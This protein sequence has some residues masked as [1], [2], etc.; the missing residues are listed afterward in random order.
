MYVKKSNQEKI[1]TIFYT[2]E[3]IIKEYWFNI[4]ST[5]KDIF[6]YFEKHIKEEG[7]SLKQNYKI[8]GKK[9]NKFNTITELIKKEKNDTI[10][11]GEIWI[12]VEEDVYFDDENDEIYYSIL[13]PKL[14][15]FELIEYNSIKSRIKIIECP[16]EI[17][18][19]SDL[20]KFNKA[21]AFC[22]SINS[23][24]ICG[25]EISGKGLNNF[26]IVNKN[27]Y[28]I[29]QKKLPV[30]KKYHSMLY[31][32]DNFIFVVGGDTLST[33]IYD[34][35]N[36]EFINWAKMNK[37]NFQPGLLINGDYVYSFTALND[38]NKDNNYFEKTNLTSKDPKWEIIYPKYDSDIKFNSYFFGISKYYDGDILFVGGEKNNP[39]Y[40]YNPI[41]N[42]IS[43]SNGKNV[44][45]PFWDKTFYKI[46]KKYN[47]CI[48]LNFNISYKIILLDKENESLEEIVC[49][50]NTGLINFNIGDDIEPGNIFIKSTIKNKKT[51]QNINIQIGLN[52][53]KNLKNQKNDY[54]Y[55]CEF[56]TINPKSLN[57]NYNLNYPNNEEDEEEF[58]EEKIII[59]NKENIQNTIPL[60]SNKNF[61][62][63]DYIYIPDSFVDEQII[64]REVDLFKNK[65]NNMP[66]D[67]IIVID[68]LNEINGKNK[69]FYP[70][71][72]M[73]F[74]K[75][76]F[77]YIPNSVI[78]DQIINRELTENKNNN[79]NNLKNENIEINRKNPKNK[80]SNEE[81]NDLIIND[82]N[83]FEQYNDDKIKTK[84][85]KDIGFL[86][87]PHSS[88]DEQIMFREIEINNNNIKNPENFEKKE[89]SKSKNEINNDEENDLIENNFE[90]YNND[91]IKT[92]E[93]N[94]IGFL[95]VPHSS[96][97]EQI[98][99]REI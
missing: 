65:N 15:P 54:I 11:D 82:E 6:N 92:K 52:P 29:K 28:K 9:I 1:K 56:N 58:N 91:K 61:H 25:G 95:Y 78:D 13:Q 76:E 67:E 49:D 71:S 26:W 31:I 62:K 7:Y 83:N 37:N 39:S 18:F 42:H 47:L 21:S 59:D 93:S 4:T 72:K 36:E 66:K 74:N 32:P 2:K 3:Q 63:K 10:L 38:I 20:D 85:S 60:K 34:I 77:L 79:S 64:N 53:K 98:M 40:I 97:D 30:S 80:I 8:F 89:N 57:N 84:E 68:D 17:L 24:Y 22:N 45:V 96:V 86:Y 70:K 12:E 81:E 35:E 43:I 41:K 5:L 19:E 44:S 50:K 73:P 88:V 55:K 69:I 99:F 48:P 33:I 16:E 51:K 23:L 14:S 87:V 90:K 94:N 75:K 27:N 46:S